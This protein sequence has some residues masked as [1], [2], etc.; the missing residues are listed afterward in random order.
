[1]R[2]WTPYLFALLLPAAGAA[3]GE[4][5]DAAGTRVS[6][7]RPVAPGVLVR[8]LLDAGEAVAGYRM[9][10]VGD[11]IGVY[12]TGDERAVVVM[13]HEL[14]GG[15]GV[16]RRHGEPGAFV[17]RWELDTVNMRIIAGSDQIERLV[18]AGPAQLE[19]LC[20]GD[21][22]LPAALH[23]H[24]PA[25]F[26]GTP[27][28]VFFSGEE[29][30]TRYKDAAGQRRHG[31]AFA[32][33]LTGRHAGTSYELPRFGKLAF[34]NVVLSPAAGRRT[35]AAL[36]DD[37]TNRQYDRAR[38]ADPATCSTQ[39]REAFFAQ[40][41][42]RPPSELYFYLGEK[43][44]AG[45]TPVERAGLT[46]GQL[47][48]VQIGAGV[49]EDRQLG[50]G[51]KTYRSSA[52]FS[53]VSLGDLSDDPDGRRLQRLSV[54]RGISQFLRLEDGAWN[55]VEGRENEFYFTTTDRYG[56]STRLHR[57]TFRDVRN[58]EAGGSIDIVLE[59][60]ARD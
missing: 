51:Q 52:D 2:R 20:S 54:E 1:M 24:T 8:P 27:E 42:N 7:L 39:C 5:P 23:A 12:R 38:I 41:D 58:P 14:K 55:T 31:R 25:G 19:N 34:E 56:G 10:G 6:M 48:G 29:L 17:S 26:V 13:N 22:P 32:H 35:V 15:T 9:T 33:V 57:L 44:A 47:Y 53:L 50:Y 49:H 37:A 4:V 45:D 21:L 28:R 18:T 30:T 11:G 40:V 36:L 16:Q 3:A 43:Q 46:N 60:R 59:G